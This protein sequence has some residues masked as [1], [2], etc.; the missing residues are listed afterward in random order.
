MKKCT[1]L[2]GLTLI[3]INLLFSQSKKEAK[4]KGSIEEKAMYSPTNSDK[5]REI[6]NKGNGNFDK[7][8][9][10]QAVK[11]FKDAISIDPNFIDAFDNLGLTFRQ[12]GNLDSAEFYYNI[13]LKKFP[14]GTVA[15]TNLG[16]LYTIT[17]QYDKA[18]YIYKE[19]SEIDSTNPEGYFGTAKIFLATQEFDSAIYYAKE[20]LFLYTITSHSFTGDALF[21]IGVSFYSKG[22][23][24]N[25]KSYLEKAQNFGF[26]VPQTLLKELNLDKKSEKD[27]IKEYKTNFENGKIKKIEYYDGYTPTG[28]W[29]EYYENGNIM[30]EYNFENGKPNGT[31]KYYYDNGQL[32]TERVLKDGLNWEVKSNFD[33]NGKP[34]DKGTLKNGTGS[35]KLYN[36]EGQLTETI[37]YEN[38][39]EI[40]K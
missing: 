2:F 3:Q 29:S 13:S 40:E 19:I 16:Q 23:I 17:K 30:S 22:D 31:C 9:F 14:H 1:L 4:T 35:M 18:L 6:Y 11:C 33:K 26:N 39:V 21:L 25:A 10:S 15:R 32:W 28:T 27:R 36:E 34:L 8:N 12:M 38:G 20:A 24:D 5:S 37:T 7:G